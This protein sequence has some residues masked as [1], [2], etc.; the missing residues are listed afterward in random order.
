MSVRSTNSET[1]L[2]H[3]PD[4]IG[5]RT[6]EQIVILVRSPHAAHP[7]LAIADAHD[8]DHAFYPRINRGN[9]DHRRTP[10]AGAVDT[11]LLGIH[12]SLRAEP[13][14]RR[15]HVHDTAVRRET[16]LRPVAVTPT[17]VV[18]GQHDIARLGQNLRDVRQVQVPHP[19]V[20][21]TQH[22][23]GTRLAGLQVAGQEQ[24]AG[25]P[26]SLA[27][28]ADRSALHDA[29]PLLICAAGARC[30]T[31]FAGAARDKEQPM[32]TIPDEYLD[33]L[34]S[35]RRRSPTSRL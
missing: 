6:L 7:A 4:A 24:V 5:G 12:Q 1:P 18:E 30:G 16:T 27:E 20:A 31:V 26:D 29:P 2:H 32:A 22:D 19:G 10:I 34:H 35:R 14:Q 13:G 9:P 28:E 25:E 8:G 15:L 23:A 33:L 11:K 21:V 17:L 3:A